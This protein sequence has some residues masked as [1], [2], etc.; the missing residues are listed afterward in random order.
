MNQCIRYTLLN[1]LLFLKKKY[2]KISLFKPKEHIKFIIFRI[3]IKTIR[4]IKKKLK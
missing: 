1:Y 2:I 4:L 3:I